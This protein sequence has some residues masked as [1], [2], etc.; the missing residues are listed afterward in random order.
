MPGGSFFG[1][2][3]IGL[4]MFAGTVWVLISRKWGR[5]R[6]ARDFPALARELALEHVPSRHTH[7]LGVLS[8]DYGGRAVRID[9]DDQRMI[10][11]RFRGTPRVD[12]RSYENS[13]RPPFDMVTIFSK[14]RTFERFFKTRFAAEPIARRISAAQKPGEHLAAFSGS[15][16]RQVQALTVTS[17]GVVCRLDFGNPPY[18]PP[19]ALRQL[20]PACVALADL[21]EPPGTPDAETNGVGDDGHAALTGEVD[22]LGLESAAPESHDDEL[23]AD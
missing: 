21:I 20:L 14:D 12:L 17:D 11:V 2:L 10:K 13:V 7:G 1:Q 6:A 3:P 5:K 9:P 23:D 8:G 15:Y 4:L 19:G 22:D 16:A 18:I